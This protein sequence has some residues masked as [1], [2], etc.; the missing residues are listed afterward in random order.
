MGTL[1]DGTLGNIVYP[2]AGLLTGHNIW[3]VY[4]KNDQSPSGGSPAYSQSPY[5]KLT[6]LNRS[7]QAGTSLDPNDKEHEIVLQWSAG[8]PT[9]TDTS[10]VNYSGVTAVGDGWYRAFLIY[11]APSTAHGDTAN[12]FVRPTHHPTDD[13]EL[14][15][16]AGC[17]VWGAQ[18]EV[19]PTRQLLAPSDYQH[20]EEQAFWA[21]TST[22]GAIPA[23]TL[24]V[25]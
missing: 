22:L 8:V 9:I 21:G 5:T 25:T 7:K 13:A 12:W 6:L 14:H 16:N 24:T 20:V 2:Q 18:F 4:L 10:G 3:S 23:S 11:N 1:G 17:Y 15:Y 19:D